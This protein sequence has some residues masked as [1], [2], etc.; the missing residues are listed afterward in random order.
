MGMHLASV[1]L[2]GV[3]LIGVHLMSAYLMGV[4]LMGMHLTGVLPRSL[5]EQP[6]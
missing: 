5:L 4:C 1:Y 2:M 3:C 6:T